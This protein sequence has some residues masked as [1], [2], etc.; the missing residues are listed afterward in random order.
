MGWIRQR[1]TVKIQRKFQIVIEEEKY[2]FIFV[3]FQIYF[4]MYVTLN[5]IKSDGLPLSN[6]K[7]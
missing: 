1:I 4:V 5:I 6:V 7:R 3:I 2:K